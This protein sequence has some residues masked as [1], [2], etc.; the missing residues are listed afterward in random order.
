M[1]LSPAQ[2]DELQRHEKV[3]DVHTD[4]LVHTHQ[5][6]DQLQTQQNAA[7]DLD[8]MDQPQLPLDGTYRYTSDGTGVNAY[9]IDT[10]SYFVSVS[11]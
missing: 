11:L 2:F 5:E 1:Q 8:R 7:W 3:Q 4:G 9:V 6:I 10:V